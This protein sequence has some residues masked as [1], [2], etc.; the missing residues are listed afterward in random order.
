MPRP[1]AYK[2]HSGTILPGVTTVVNLLD[3]GF[4]MTHA[5]WKLGMKNIDY[6]KEWNRKRDIGTFTHL[7]IGEFLGN[8]LSP[9]KEDTEGNTYDWYYLAPESITKNYSDIELAEMFDLADENFEIYKDYHRE[10][11]INPVFVEQPFISEY[12]QYGGTLD[13]VAR[14]ADERLL[15]IDFKTSP[16]IYTGHVIQL[17][18]Y[19]WL[20]KESG[21]PVEC[22]F[23]LSID[24][25]KWHEH[26]FEQDD[27][28]MYF[29][30]FKVLRQ[31]YFINKHLKV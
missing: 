4:G 31:A 5:A 24:T 23:I 11:G 6:K 30:M 12:Y 9:R 8:I 21:N 28:Y 19:N 15:L 20:L 1:E 14:T 10:M 3:K 2:N 16:R 29:E 17:S 18:A 25:G 13:L 27:L 7:A 26:I 22:A